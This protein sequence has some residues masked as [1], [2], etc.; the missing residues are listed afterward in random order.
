MLIQTTKKKTKKTASYRFNS[1]LLDEF[2][3]LC[4]R[5][6]LVQVQILENAMRKAIEE[7]KGMENEK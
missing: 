6:D 5:N 3:E 1:S 7:I 2:R 4:K